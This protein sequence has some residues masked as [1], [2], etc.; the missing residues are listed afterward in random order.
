LLKE[1]NSSGKNE[2]KLMYT[3]HKEILK[4]IEKELKR[5]NEKQIM[6]ISM[7]YRRQE[8]QV[9]NDLE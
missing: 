4:H 5:E 1:S 9:Q 3:G 6:A 7:K 2:R 8:A